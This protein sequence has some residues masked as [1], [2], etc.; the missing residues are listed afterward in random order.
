MKRIRLQEKLQ[1]LKE[2]FHK[3]DKNENQKDDAY[4]ALKGEV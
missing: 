1:K 2:N 4:L 3:K